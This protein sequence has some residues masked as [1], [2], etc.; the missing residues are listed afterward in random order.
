M[1][2]GTLLT[3]FCEEFVNILKS[4]EVKRLVFTKT[5][6]SKASLLLT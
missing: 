1:F 3:V 5:V 6:Y 4:P 2:A